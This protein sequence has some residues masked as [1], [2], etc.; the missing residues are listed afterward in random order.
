M[1]RG[2]AGCLVHHPTQDPTFALLKAIG[3]SDSAKA[4]GRRTGGRGGRSAAREAR[5]SDEGSLCGVP[6]AADPPGSLGA[7][8]QELGKRLL[9]VCHVQHL[10]PMVT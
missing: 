10:S 5:F 3:V 7:K 2:F 4:G 8:L 6:E 9:Q 1:L